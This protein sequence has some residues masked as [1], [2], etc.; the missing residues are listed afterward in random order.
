MRLSPKP[1]HLHF[2]VEG[3]GNRHA[4]LKQHSSTSC[5]SSGRLA[6]IPP[7]RDIR[8]QQF[9]AEE[10]ARNGGHEAEQR[11][12][13]DETRPREIGDRNL[14]FPNRFDHA[15]HTDSRA[16][17][18]LERITPVTVDAAPNDVGTFQ[19]GDRSHVNAPFGGHQVFALDEQETEIAGE[20]GLFEIGFAPR[21]RRQQ[22]QARLA[23][24]GAGGEAGAKVAEEWRESFDIELPIKTGDRA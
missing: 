9:F 10:M 11:S 19:A 7:S 18:E 2:E 14:T 3:A 16:S 20:I 5:R 17:I 15:R 24:F 6:A 4:G 13:F 12:R 23:A 1:G 21:T 8:Q 22:A